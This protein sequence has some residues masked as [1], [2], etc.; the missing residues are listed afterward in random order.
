MPV[1]YKDDG[2]AERHGATSRCINA[3][4]A[5]K[6]ADDQVGDAPRHKKLVQLRTVKG[7]RSSL[8]QE[9]IAWVN[10]ERWREGP[11]IGSVVHVTTLRLVLD[12]HDEGSGSACFAGNQVD[13]IDYA[14]DIVR[15]VLA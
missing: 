11:A 1:R 13:S 14:I 6:A 12:D 10:L 9:N 7:V 4:L 8:P 5:L 15:D 2:V 3:E